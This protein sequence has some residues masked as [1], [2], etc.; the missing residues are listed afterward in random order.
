M[1]QPKIL[2]VEDDPNSALL[3]KDFLT[4]KGFDIDHVTDG[5]SAVSKIEANAFSIVILDLRLP[6]QNGFVTAEKIRQLPVGASV[7]II[8]LTAF[9]DTQN[10]LRAYQSGV[11]FV[12]PKPVNI[13]ELY[14]VVNNLVQLQAHSW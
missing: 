2:I 11:N 6:G 12:L 9:A 4:L 8:V 14:Y 10:K 13:K 3:V 5:L 7:P 1:D